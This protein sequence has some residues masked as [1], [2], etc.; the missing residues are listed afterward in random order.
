[1][2]NQPTKARQ[3]WGDNKKKCAPAHVALKNKIKRPSNHRKLTTKKRKMENKMT[4]A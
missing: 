4:R 3:W 2:K 1:M